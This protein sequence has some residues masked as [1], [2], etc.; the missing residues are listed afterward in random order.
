MAD[1]FKEVD[2]DLRRDQASRLWSKYGR[3]AISAAMAIVLAVAGFKT[4]EWW[5]TKQRLERSDRFAAAVAVLAEGDEDLAKEQFNAL[6]Q[7]GDGFSVLAAF[8]EA[9]LHANAGEIRAAVAIWDRL[10]E[11]PK[12]GAAFQGAALLLSVMHQANDGD[13]VALE[14]RL[15]PL[16]A[17]DSGYRALALELTAALAMR[18]DDLAR[19]REIYTQIA[20]DLEAPVGLRARASQML[21]ALEK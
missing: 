2:E 12:A 19:A 5:D 16:L 20:D 4:W 17:N 7:S 14:A 13:P 3:Y 15:A 6:A 10:A 18:Q 8:N 11:D 21:N 9:R 1:I